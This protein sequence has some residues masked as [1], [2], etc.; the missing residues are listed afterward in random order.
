MSIS[1]FAP[2]EKHDGNV[3]LAFFPI[4]AGII[5]LCF[6][7]ESTSLIWSLLVGYAIMTCMKLTDILLSKDKLVVHDTCISKVLIL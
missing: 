6:L 3:I 5:E 2:Y 7:R 1:R 4:I